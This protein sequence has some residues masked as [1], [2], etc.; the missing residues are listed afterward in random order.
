MYRKPKFLEI[1]HDIRQQMAAEGEYDMN[2][3]LQ[4]I[5]QRSAPLEPEPEPKRASA[6]R[7][8]KARRSP[9]TK[10]QKKL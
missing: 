6:A 5:E 4:L 3:F 7:V 8:V 10:A 2:R 9:A 1:L